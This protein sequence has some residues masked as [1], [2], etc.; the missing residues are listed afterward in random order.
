MSNIQNKDEASFYGIEAP[1]TPAKKK[2]KRR[3]DNQRIAL[4]SPILKVEYSASWIAR[5]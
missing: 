1:K 5:V 2:L 4:N 3:V